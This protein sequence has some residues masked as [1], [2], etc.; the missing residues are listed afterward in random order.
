MFNNYNKTLIKKIDNLKRIKSQI[1]KKSSHN[2]YNYTIFKNKSYSLENS[3]SYLN[4]STNCNFS[5]SNLIRNYYNLNKNNQYKKFNKY[6]S[7]PNFRVNKNNSVDIIYENEKYKIIT[8]KIEENQEKKYFFRK[9]PR[10][11][12]SYRV[13]KN[14]VVCLKYDK[15]KDN[16]K[17]KTIKMIYK[18]NSIKNN[19][20][21][22]LP[23]MIKIIKN[24]KKIYNEVFYQPWKYPEFFQN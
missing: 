8:N 2:T 3:K 18:L 22:I 15:P 24:N 16:I 9:I 6:P 4:N 21:Y 13:D 12:Y 1:D 17:K 7:L 14:N 23:R 10:F 20:D 11:N 19:K 5:I